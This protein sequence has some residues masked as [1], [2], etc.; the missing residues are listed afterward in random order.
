MSEAFDPVKF[1]M[2]KVKKEMKMSDEWNEQ[3]ETKSNEATKGC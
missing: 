1:A 3:K 2:S